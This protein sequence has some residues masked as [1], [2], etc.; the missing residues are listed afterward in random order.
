MEGPAGG[1]AEEGRMSAWLNHVVGACDAAAQEVARLRRAIAEIDARLPD[2]AAAVRRA[3]RR[4]STRWAYLREDQ[5]P[6]E[7]RAAWQ[8][9]DTSLSKRF[10]L[11]E[12]LASHEQDQ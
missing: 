1:P 8:I 12:K 4:T 11:Q 5:W 3:K 10:I 6:S 7:F 9:L 2:E